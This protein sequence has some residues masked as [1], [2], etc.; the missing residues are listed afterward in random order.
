MRRLLISLLPCASALALCMATSP[1]V[2]AE[3]PGGTPTFTSDATIDNPWV[4]FRDYRI[5]IYEQTKGGSDKYVIDVFTGRTRTFSWNGSSVTCRELQEWEIEDGGILEISL[6]W[7]AQATNGTVYYFGETV[8]QY[9]DGEIVA[10]G[11]SWL[12]GG[13]QAGDPAGTVTA[14][15]PTVF[16]PRHPAVGDVWKAEDLPD[17]G[18]EEFDTVL[19]IRKN[20]RVPLGRFR[21]VLLVQEETPDVGTKWYAKG[22]GFIQQA[23]DEETI[24]LV[25]VEDADDADD[26]AEELDE[27]VEELLAGE[28]EPD[29]GHGRR[30]CDDEDDD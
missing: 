18:I 29:R 11:G 27:L 22:F 5:R 28:W 30:D 25:E 7:F 9:E 15:D 2:G 26:M 6:N 17:E 12:V 16:M 19:R 3:V 13:P 21:R 1:P 24:S 10:H 8:D 14:S 20:L 23:D 4:P